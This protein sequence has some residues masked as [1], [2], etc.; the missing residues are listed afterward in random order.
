MGFTPAEV[1]AMSLW[2]FSA[3]IEGWNKARGDGK[4]LPPSE[5]EYDEIISRMIH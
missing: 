5:E 3:S 2:E 1:D 4:P